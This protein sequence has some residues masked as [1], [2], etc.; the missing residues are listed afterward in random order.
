MKFISGVW[1]NSKNHVIVE[2]IRTHAIATPEPCQ[3][4]KVAAIRDACNRRGLRV[5][6]FFLLILLFKQVSGCT[7]AKNVY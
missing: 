6:Y 5:T 2:A 1:S 7:Q 3:G 4:R